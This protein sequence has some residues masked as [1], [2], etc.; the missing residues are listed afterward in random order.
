MVVG[1]RLTAHRRPGR[2]SRLVAC[3]L[4]LVLSPVVVQVRW[5]SEVCGAGV[6]PGATS[7]KTSDKLGSPLVRSQRRC[8]GGDRASGEPR[9]LLAARSASAR[10]PLADRSGVARCGPEDEET[11]PGPGA[12]VSSVRRGALPLKSLPRGEAR[13]G[14]ESSRRPPAWPLGRLFRQVCALGRRLG[15]QR[16][17]GEFSPTASPACFPGADLHRSAFGEAGEAGE[18]P[19][20]DPWRSG[21]PGVGVPPSPSRAATGRAVPVASP[22]NP[23]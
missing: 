1:H 15:R 12:V 6:W 23:S 3:R 22:F 5:V 14:A 18:V 13:G 10:T 9:N 21:F 17:G 11:T 8:G 4:S 2:G 20:R 16:G 19:L 7:D